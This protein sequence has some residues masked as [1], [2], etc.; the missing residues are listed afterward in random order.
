LSA[1]FTNGWLGAVEFLVAVAAPD[2]FNE[3]G[4]N[5]EVVGFAVVG[6]PDLVGVCATE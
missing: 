5:S 4:G 1:I 2:S 6:E 3:S